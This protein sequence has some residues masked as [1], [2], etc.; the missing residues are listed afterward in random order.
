MKRVFIIIFIFLSLQLYAKISKNF[1]LK[2]GLTS[3]NLKMELKNRENPNHK[4]KYGFN[5]SIF[6]DLYIME[7]I[8]I[9][10]NIQYSQKGFKFSSYTTYI[11]TFSIESLIKYK[12]QRNKMNPY[13]SI[14]PRLDYLHSIGTD[15][16]YNPAAEYLIYWEEYTFK[17]FS[18]GVSLNIGTEFKFLNKHIL[19]IELEYNYDFKNIYRKQNPGIKGL[20]NNSIDICIGTK[21]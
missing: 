16:K 8:S 10:P 5:F 1:G 13:F 7:S 19:L 14:G 21:F 9:Y 6:Y 12:I 18:F 2:L 11:N 17:N 15:F 4:R 3:S 20:Y